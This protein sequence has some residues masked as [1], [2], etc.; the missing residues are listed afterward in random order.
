MLETVKYLMG[1]P[2]PSGYGSKTTAEDVTAGAAA[3]SDLRCIT[4]IVTGNDDTYATPYKSIKF[5]NA[6][7]QR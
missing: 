2:G 7:K 6:R 5:A 1:S 4:A 3:C